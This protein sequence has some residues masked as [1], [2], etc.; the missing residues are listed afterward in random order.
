[1]VLNATALT[2]ALLAKLKAPEYRVDDAVGVLP[3]VV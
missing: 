1:M 2:V 3:S